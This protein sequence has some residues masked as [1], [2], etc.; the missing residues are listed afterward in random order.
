MYIHLFSFTGRGS[1]VTIMTTI[2][3]SSAGQADVAGKAQDAA[4]QSDPEISRA[5]RLSVW[6]G[7]FFSAML[8][9]TDTFAVAAAV[10]LKAPTI[11]IGLL[12]GL[13][14]FSGS[15]GQLLIASV[16][17]P[18]M[19]RKKYVLWG[20][21]GQSIFLAVVALSGL[22]PDTVRSWAYVI[23]FTIQGF[24]ANVVGGLWM[25]WMSDLVN[26]RQR[27]RYFAHRNRVI[28]TAQLVCGLAAGA[29]AFKHTVATSGWEFFLAIFTSAALLRTVST[30]ILRAQYEPTVQLNQAATS[31]FKK[32]PVNKPFLYFCVA[33]ALMQGMVMLASPFF[34]VWSVRDLHFTYFSLAIATSS[35]VLGSVLSLSFWGKLS[36]R[37]GHHR[38]LLTTGLLIAL[39]PF[40]FLFTGNVVMI[41]VFN[42]Y[43]GIVWGGYNLS[44][45]NHMLMLLSG[46]KNTER[47]IS[48][49]NA[50]TGISVFIF[51]FVGGAVAPL[52]PKIL[53]WQLQ[54]LFLLSALLRIAVYVALFPGLPHHG[55]DRETIKA[56]LR[57]FV[58]HARDHR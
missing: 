18:T 58:R 8:A 49:A 12:A 33:T 41:C 53:T 27:G 23:A 51:S 1:V 39:V 16:F 35:T 43:T 32:W 28:N 19:S 15:L 44:N 46:S 54:S 14:L 31:R 56:H 6:D 29:L 20:T 10:N 13:P 24:F 25:A 5:L 9:L 3:R 42:F 30:L 7:A 45:F 26:E 22:L 38:I 47:Q 50:L 2:V 17:S 52:L 40:P 37:I 11:A 21:T 4:Q 57:L 55:Q 36:D 34:S 48:F